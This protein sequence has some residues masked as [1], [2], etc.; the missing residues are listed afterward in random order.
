MSF[1]TNLAAAIQDSARYK[2][3]KAREVKRTLGITLDVPE[4][5]EKYEEDTDTLT[6]V[7]H[8]YPEDHRLQGAFFYQNGTYKGHQT[9]RYRSTR[10]LKTLKESTNPESPHAQRA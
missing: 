9:R 4:Y 7:S 5:V 6:V 10:N 8:Y 1:E 3:Q 2:T